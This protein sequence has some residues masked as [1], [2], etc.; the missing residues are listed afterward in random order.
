MLDKSL[1]YFNVIMK[2]PAGMSI[3]DFRLPREF[4]FE[5]FADGG[6]EEWADIETSVG[7]FA[8]VQEALAYFKA[9]YLPNVIDLRQ[10]LLFVREAGGKAVGTITS[11]WNYT[12]ARRDPSVHWL[13]VRHEYQGLGLGKAL[14][15]ACLK[16][17]ALLE[18]ERDVYLH[19]QTWSYKAIDIYL[20]IGF[21]FVEDGSFG[22][23]HND[24]DQAMPILKQLIPSLR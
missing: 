14:V 17:L 15:A 2:R 6:E 5:W 16:R 23:Y 21:T 12:G 7:E 1:P 9:T 11:W 13:A 22:T 18:G 19:T 24:Y 4:S 20:K 3:P 8:D 10:R